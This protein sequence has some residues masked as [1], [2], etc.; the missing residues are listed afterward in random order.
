MELPLCLSFKEL[1]HRIS[2]EHSKLDILRIV[3]LV[4]PADWKMTVSFRS[5]NPHLLFSLDSSIDP[6]VIISCTPLGLFDYGELRF[7]RNGRTYRVNWRELYKSD[8]LGTRLHFSEVDNV[9]CPECFI[10][11]SGTKGETLPPEFGESNWVRDYLLSNTWMGSKGIAQKKFQFRVVSMGHEFTVRNEW[12]HSESADRARQEEQPLFEGEYPL[13]S[14][15]AGTLYFTQFWQKKEKM[16]RWTESGLANKD[17]LN[18]IGWSNPLE[19]L[20]PGELEIRFPQRTLS[21]CGTYARTESLVSLI[22]HARS[23]CAN[24]KEYAQYKVFEGE[25]ETLAQKISAERIDKRKEQVRSGSF[26]YWNKKL[27]YKLPTNENE[28]VALHQKLEGMGGVPLPVFSSLEYTPKL[29]I[30]AIANF[31]IETTEAL[32]QFSTVEFEYR[33]ENFFSHKH[34]V[35]HTDLIICWDGGGPVRDGTLKQDTTRNWLSYL[36]KGER[37]IPVIKV[38]HYPGLRIC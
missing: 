6:G 7:G 28:L 16:F 23:R 26:V 12:Q 8:P 27:V 14:P 33:L 20:P 35:G 1:A 21:P 4:E 38:R 2:L 11:L 18:D 10:E 5:G 19:L 32:H 30:D 13:G 15:P 9:D 22:E 24:I 17:D 34:S 25:C 29:G 3:N 31:K 37:V 36:Y